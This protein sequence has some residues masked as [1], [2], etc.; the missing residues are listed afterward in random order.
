MVKKECWHVSTR[1]SQQYSKSQTSYS[2]VPT[3]SDMQELP[4][5]EWV[6]AC[7]YRNFSYKQKTTHQNVQVHVQLTVIQKLVGCYTLCLGEKRHPV[8]I[9][10]VSIQIPWGMFL[11]RIGKTLW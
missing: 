2:W 8:H 1:L 7:K 11:R 4:N 10:F 5:I 9:V 3:N 6:T